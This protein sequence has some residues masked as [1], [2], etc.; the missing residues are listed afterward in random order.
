MALLNLDPDKRK[1]RALSKVVEI[2][3][4]GGI[5]IYPTDTVYAIGCN[6]FHPRAVEKICKFRG[7]DPNKSNLSLICYD[8]SNISEYAKIDNSTFQVLK[9]NLP[10]PFTFILN[11]SSHLP[12]LFK[13]R[14]EVGIRIP[15]NNIIR[16]I[17]YELGNPILTSS[18]KDYDEMTEYETDPELLNEKYGHL[19]DLVID[20]GIGGTIGSTIVDC[21]KD[22]FTIIREGKDKLEL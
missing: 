6:I 18:V 13:N 11:G 9:H 22:E 12:R 4:N 5:I 15:D 7:I 21:T 19:V 17:V 10:G 2:L 14:K 1:S 3:R 8:L 20:G 16:T